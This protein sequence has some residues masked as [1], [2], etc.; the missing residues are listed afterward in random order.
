MKIF[1]FRDVDNELGFSLAR[2]QM[3]NPSSVI[4]LTANDVDWDTDLWGELL[5][6]LD[7]RHPDLGEVIEIVLP[8]KLQVRSYRFEPKLPTTPVFE[9]VPT[10]KPV[11]L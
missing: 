4:G 2:P 11:T 7:F 10:T 8:Y 5:D 3:R 6:G 9:E 1:I